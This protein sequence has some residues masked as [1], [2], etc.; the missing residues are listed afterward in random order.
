ML[1]SLVD[2]NFVVKI[3]RHWYGAR[4][5]LILADEVGRSDDEGLA[6]QRLCQLMDSWAGQVSVV[7]SAFSD[8]EGAVNMFNASIRTVEFQILIVLGTDT[9]NCF[10]SVLTVWDRNRTKNAI[11]AYR[12]S[13]A[14]GATAG[15]AR[16]VQYLTAELNKTRFKGPSGGSIMGCIAKLGDMGVNL[17]PQ[18]RA[19]ELE[20]R[21]GGTARDVG[22]TGLPLPAAGSSQPHQVTA[23]GHIPGKR[24]GGGE[25]NLTTEA[26]YANSRS[27]ACGLLVRELV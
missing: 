22:L 5:L 11:L 16:A 20:A 9:F 24:A 26:F 2:L 7:M 12:I 18:F 4:P 8:Y 6:R 13:L 25:A 23:A 15:Y 14:W 27:L 1:Q 3:L 17:P 21:A 10:Q 19:D